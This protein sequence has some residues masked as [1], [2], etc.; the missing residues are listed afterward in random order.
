MLVNKGIHRD[1]KTSERKCPP[2]AI[3][4]KPNR[5]PRLNENTSA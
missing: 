3:L 1:Q 5:Q 2:A 4:A